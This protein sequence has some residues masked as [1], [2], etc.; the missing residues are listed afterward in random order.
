MLAFLYGEPGRFRAAISPIFHLQEPYPNRY[1]SGMSIFDHRP[2]DLISRQEYL[3]SKDSCLGLD[4]IDPGY[5]HTARFII[6][7]HTPDFF[8]GDY[9]VIVEGIEHP[10]PRLP[11]QSASK[12]TLGYSVL[13]L[14]LEEENTDPEKNPA[15]VWPIDT[16][17]NLVSYRPWGHAFIPVQFGYLLDATTFEELESSEELTGSPEPHDRPVTPVTA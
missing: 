8:A 14:P 3:D 1:D 5:I 10:R 17:G 7:R 6:N 4:E 9:F 15:D 13:L 16:D 12:L 2:V 11:W